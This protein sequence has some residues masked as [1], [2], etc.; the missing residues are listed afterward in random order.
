[1]VV[2]VVAEV[3]LLVVEAVLLLARPVLWPGRHGIRVA[4]AGGGRLGRESR[5]GG[6]GEEGASRSVQRKN[7]L[8]VRL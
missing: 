8:W 7:G 2:V 1:M 5:G 3:L 6:G 4:G